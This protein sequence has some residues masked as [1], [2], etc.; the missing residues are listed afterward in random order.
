MEERLQH[1]SMAEFPTTVLDAL[2]SG[3]INRLKIQ[4]TNQ[5]WLTLTES[6]PQQRAYLQALACESLTANATLPPP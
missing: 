6:S 5:T 1:Q 4:S 2:A 3:Q